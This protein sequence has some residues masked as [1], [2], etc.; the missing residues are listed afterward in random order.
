MSEKVKITAIVPTFN[1][2]HNIE[3]VL[4]S[5]A[6][7][8]EIMVVDSFSTDKTIELAKKYT[9]FI[10]QR[11]FENSASQKNWAI[12]QATYEWI[13]LI[14]A[15]ERVSPELEKEILE[16]INSNPKEVGFW[17]YRTNY[18]M[19]EPLKNGAFKKDKVIRLFR[20][21]KCKYEYKSVHAEIIAAGTVGWLKGKLN[22][23]TYISLDHHLEKMNRYA[24]WQ[25]DDLNKKMGTITP[26]HLILK[27]CF[28]FFK[29]Y[30]VQGGFKD[31]LPGF[32]MA[33]IAAYSVVTRYFKV[34]LLRR[35]LK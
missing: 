30:I 33:I 20:K 11:E 34:W 35:N 26:F 16:K 27:P 18:F 19:G 8:D 6:F 13:I 31:G 22:H 15:D 2:E 1:E 29:E 5:V 17:M 24:W 10:I 21:N 32:T 12:P 9:N 14:D 3:E 7:A 25:A 23:N 28:R 4:K